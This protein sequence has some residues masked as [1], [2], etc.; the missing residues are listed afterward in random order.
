MGTETA[1]KNKV[2]TLLQNRG[3][4]VIKYWGG[5]NY[6]KKGV[7]DLLVC[8]DGRFIGIELK[9]PTGEP[10][11]LQ[12]YNLRKIHQAGGLAILLYPKDLNT[13][14]QLL[15]NLENETLYSVFVNQ[16]ETIANERGV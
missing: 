10:S 7:P 12:L 15:D 14:K 13:F 3:C 2:K 8:C 5:G 6:T 11:D 16:W 1:F 4:Y 9:A